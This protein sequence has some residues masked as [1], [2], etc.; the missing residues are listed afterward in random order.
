MR[1]MRPQTR[2]A[3]HMPA[4]QTHRK[5]RHTGKPDT[6]ENMCLA[7]LEASPGIEPGYTDLQSAA[8]PLRH[9]AGYKLC[10][11]FK[12]GFGKMP[13]AWRSRDVPQQERKVRVPCTIKKALPCALRHSCCTLTVYAPL[14]SKQ[15]GVFYCT[16]PRLCPA[17][18]LSP[19]SGDGTGA[20]RSGGGNTRSR[21]TRL[22][23]WLWFWFWPPGSAFVPPPLSAALTGAGSL[24]RSSGITSGG[25]G[26][27]SIS[28]SLPRPEIRSA[29]NWPSTYS[30][31]PSSNPSPLAQPARHIMARHTPQ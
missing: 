28:T 10:L 9:E 14:H 11:N 15:Y 2:H 13:C 5:T 18:G 19:V 29:I 17:C 27:A 25:R 4:G 24:D 26:V 7:Y 30:G 8:S 31:R 20:R 22:R 21:D 23:L 3:R 16:S 1:S 6:P 12:S